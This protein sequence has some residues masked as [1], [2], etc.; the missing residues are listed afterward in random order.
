MIR[1]I[2][3]CDR[4]GTVTEVAYRIKTFTI[5][6]D[7]VA[8]RRVD[9]DVLRAQLDRFF[10]RRVASGIRKT[11]FFRRAEDLRQVQRVQIRADAGVGHGDDRFLP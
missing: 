3:V 9:R 4:C 8:E 10:L 2:L 1:K 7:D 11:V 6:A 5:T